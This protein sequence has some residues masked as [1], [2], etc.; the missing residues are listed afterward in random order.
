MILALAGGVGG[1]KLAHG[2]ARVLDP[3]GLVIAV[4]TA[5]DFRHLGLHISPD[6][7]SVMYKLAGL[8][9]EVRG[10]GQRDETWQFMEMLGRLG[11][12]DWFNL[13]DRDL[14]IHMVRTRRLM[15]GESLT[16]A[17][18]GLCRTLG[19][20]HVIAPMSDDPVAT[21]IETDDGVLPFQH[22]FVRLRCEPPVCGVSF[23]GAAEARPSPPVA[24]ALARDD[25][26]A[27]VLC[28]SNPF[29]SIDPVAAVPGIGEALAGRKVP[30]V[31]VSPIIGGAAVKGPA[32]DMMA[33]RGLPVSPVGVAR[34]YDGRI[35]GLVI[36][37][38]DAKLAADVEREGVKTL[39]TA[40]LMKTADDEARL[41]EE[42]LAFACR[43]SG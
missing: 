33:Q 19:I 10:W 15:A 21:M 23:E 1:A 2:L 7:D 6:L 36:D 35:D 30:L 17:T 20:E 24:A 31:A 41:A 25:L 37:E 22:W 29:V 8:N 9:D 32:A 26:E 5:D 14:A 28:P 18:A 11:G 3:S 42:T 43:L 12:E 40:T 38:A 27:I 16:E 13:G 34:Y 4:N 39:V